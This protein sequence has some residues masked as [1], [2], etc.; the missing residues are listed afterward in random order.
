MLFLCL[1]QMETGFFLHA[2]PASLDSL[3]TWEL[4]EESICAYMC[5]YFEQRYIKMVF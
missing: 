5:V 2:F 1:K 4:A 3:S